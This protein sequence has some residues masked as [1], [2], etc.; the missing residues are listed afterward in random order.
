M[1]EA[2]CGD[3]VPDIA[4]LIRATTCCRCDRHCERR[5]AIHASAQEK[6]DCVVASLLAMTLVSAWHSGSTQTGAPCPLFRHARYC[7]LPAPTLGF[8][9]ARGRRCA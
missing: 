2:T 3:T 7:P 8:R 4:S 1:S 6:M 9:A 5:E